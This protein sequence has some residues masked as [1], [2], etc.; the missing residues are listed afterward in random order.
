MYDIKIE[1]DEIW[2]K[3][4]ILLEHCEL[5]SRFTLISVVIGSLPVNCVADL[6]RVKEMAIEML[7]LIQNTD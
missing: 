3:K 5:F 1:T 2:K 4:W 6:M 7:K